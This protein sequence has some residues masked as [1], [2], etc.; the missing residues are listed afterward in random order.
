MAKGEIV[1]MTKEQA[2]ARITDE[3]H[4]KAIAE[5]SAPQLRF[6]EN[7]GVKKRP[8]TFAEARRLIDKAKK[9]RRL[10]RDA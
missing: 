3:M 9:K 2:T 8:A 5:P 6:L 4:K 7:L 10:Y 1:Q